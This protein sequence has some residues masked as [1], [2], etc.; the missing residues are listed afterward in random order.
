M[1]VSLDFMHEMGAQNMPQQYE[2]P[3]NWEDFT[4]KVLEDEQKAVAAGA[5]PTLK[6]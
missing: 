6:K 5:Y 1:Y 4:F 2:W 3:H